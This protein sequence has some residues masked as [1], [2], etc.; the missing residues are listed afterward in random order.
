MPLCRTTSVHNVVH[1]FL[2]QEGQ[3]SFRK[4]HKQR[5]GMSVHILQ[6]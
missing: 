3:Y 1:K 4:I 6:F 2:I 5:M